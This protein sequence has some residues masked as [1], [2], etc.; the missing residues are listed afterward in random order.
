MTSEGV[1]VNNRVAL[2][3][4]ACDIPATRKVCGF[5]GHNASLACNKGFKKFPVQFGS[6]TDYSGYD[7]STWTLRSC[8]MHRRHCG[9]ISKRLQ[10]LT[11]SGTLWKRSLHN[12]PSSS[13]SP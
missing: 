7:R 6:S 1:Q 10:K 5:I 9:E 2:S 11:L 4:V 3:C 12:E 8:S 13:F